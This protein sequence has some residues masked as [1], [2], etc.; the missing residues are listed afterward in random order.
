MVNTQGNQNPTQRLERLFFDTQLGTTLNSRVGR[1][2]CAHHRQKYHK[3]CY[4]HD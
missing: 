3:I 4:K 1:S 2:L